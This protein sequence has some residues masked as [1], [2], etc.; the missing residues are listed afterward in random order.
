MKY[1]NVY[2]SRHA[3][4]RDNTTADILAIGDS[5]FWYPMPGGS[6]INFIGDVVRPKGHKILVAGNNGA[7]AY[8]YVKGKYREQVKG[9]LGFY[10]SSASAVLISGGGNDFA[11]FSDLRP[12]L[13]D[14]CQGATTPQACFRPGP[15]EGSVDFLASKMYEN[16]ALLV[17][18]ILAVVPVSA[19][20][21]VHTYDYAVPDGRG[22]LG[23]EAWLKPALEDAQVPPGLHQPCINLLMDTAHSVLSRITQG[24]GGRVVL[25]DS[26]GVLGQQDWA[27][28]LHPR[29]TG[30]K[31][32]ATQKWKPALQALG[33]A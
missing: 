17:T 30:F 26:R 16:Y 2:W 10:G 8:D 28:E 24:A 9:L 22:V 14:T 12:L 1:K 6:L 4:D 11:G 18:R 7:E 20:I 31:K 25:V 23:G 13:N 3:M 32:L 33:L 19:P 29:P 5:W 21:L 15:D 27:N